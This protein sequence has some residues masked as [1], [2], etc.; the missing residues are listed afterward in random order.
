MYWKSPRDGMCCECRPN[1][2]DPCDACP[3][4]VTVELT[5]SG[6]TACCTASNSRLT[7]L[8]S[9]NGTHT[10][11]REESGEYSLELL[12]A[13][14]LQWFSEADC[15]TL[16]STDESQSVTIRF[17]CST[18]GAVLDIFITDTGERLFY[19]E[20]TPPGAGELFVFE[21]A[22][23]CSAFQPYTFGGG[24]TVT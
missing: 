21:G 17:S 13:V 9:I 20:I 14:S 3:T 6:L 11:T 23:A 2:C 8:G 19:S 22:A 7:G 12:S 4:A 24:A 5:V 18:E 10:L 1:V 15:T 16:F